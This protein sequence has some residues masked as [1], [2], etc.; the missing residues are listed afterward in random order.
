MLSLCA[1]ASTPKCVC[2]LM[3][4]SA[5]ACSTWVRRSEDSLRYR[6]LPLTLFEVVVSSCVA[7]ASWPANSGGSPNFCLFVVVLKTYFYLYFCLC[8]IRSIL[9]VCASIYIWWGGVCAHLSLD[10]S[11]GTV[12]VCGSQ[13]PDEFWE[14]QVL[15]KSKNCF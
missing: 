14:T 1:G 3:C 2:A 11:L 7:Q 5:N 13:A 6:S 12:I 8:L 10:R 15:W 4:V 9:S